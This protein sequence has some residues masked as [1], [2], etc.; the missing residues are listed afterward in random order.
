MSDTES[1]YCTP[2][3]LIEALKIPEQEARDIVNKCVQNNMHNFREKFD[4]KRAAANR[5]FHLSDG[6]S[7]IS[8]DLWDEWD[9]DG[10]MRHIYGKDLLKFIKQYTKK[11]ST[12]QRVGKLPSSRLAQ[13]FQV[14]LNSIS[15]D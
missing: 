1:Y 6:R 8:D 14:L 4:S 2:E 12:R 10:S 3:Y 15:R 5:L 11:Y 9:R 7:P 13:E